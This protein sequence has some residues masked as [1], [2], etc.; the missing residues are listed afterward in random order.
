MFKKKHDQDSAAKSW[1]WST[2]NEKN[3]KNLKKKT[4][5]R[6]QQ[7]KAVA[8]RQKNEEKNLN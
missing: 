2:K 6:T 3:L 8:S 5:I 4:M 7:Q 1:S